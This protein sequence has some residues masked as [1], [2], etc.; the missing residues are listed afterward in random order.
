MNI[1]VVGCGR[2]GSTLANQLSEKEHDVSVIDQNESSFALLDDNFTGLTF[3]GVAIDNDLLEKAGI[4]SCDAVCAVTDDDDVNIMVSEIA[5]VIYK[6]EKVLTRIISPEKEDVFESF[7]LT[8]VCPTHLTA[9]AIISSL[10]EYEDEKY[11]QYGCNKIKFFTMKAP[12]EYDNI[13]VHDIEF[14]DNEILFAIIP[15]K[16]GAFKLVDNNNIK[17]EEGD[18]LIFS[19]LID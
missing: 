15:K 10:D 12:E 14:E 18:T 5:R 9:D 6:K 1:L 16:T 11:L 17:I 8:T 19:R 4:N 13:K 2:V 7:G 3:R